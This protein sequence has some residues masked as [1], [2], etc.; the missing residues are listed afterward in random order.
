MYMLI[1]NYYVIIMYYVKF[2]QSD[3]K[4]LWSLLGNHGKFLLV[5]WPRPYINPSATSCG[6]MWIRGSRKEII[7]PLEIL[8]AG[9]VGQLSVHKSDDGHGSSSVRQVELSDADLTNCQ[10]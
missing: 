7:F 5:L 4:N 10:Y 6:W 2:V 1:K 3:K 9:T 8:L